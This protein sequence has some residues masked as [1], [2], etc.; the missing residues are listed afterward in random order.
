MIFLQSIVQTLYRFCINLERKQVV[1]SYVR[2]GK[3]REVPLPLT[4][5]LDCLAKSESKKIN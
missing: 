5:C 2:K 4:V 3:R 1:A